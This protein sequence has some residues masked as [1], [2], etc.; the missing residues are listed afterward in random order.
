MPF[1]RNHVGTGNV[2]AI[3]FPRNVSYQRRAHFERRLED[4]NARDPS[5]RISVAICV[6]LGLSIIDRTNIHYSIDG[7]NIFSRN[8]ITMQPVGCANLETRTYNT[9]VSNSENDGRNW[10][11]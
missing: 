10:L 1:D 5:S 3:L 2:F 11:T 8:N 4:S 7:E 6:F 9:R